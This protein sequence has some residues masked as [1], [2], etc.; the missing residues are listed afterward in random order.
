MPTVH[1]P[2]AATTSLNPHRSRYQKIFATNAGPNPSQRQQRNCPDYC[3]CDRDC[4]D[5]RTP[6]LQPC[7]SPCVTPSVYWPRS[8]SGGIPR[9][10][11]MTNWRNSESIQVAQSNLKPTVRL[12][13]G[14]PEHRPAQANQ[15]HLERAALGLRCAVLRTSFPCAS[16]APASCWAGLLPLVNKRRGFLRF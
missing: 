5:A 11:R 4:H 12:S 13:F 2:V 1:M 9:P 10:G 14:M 6:H 7:A 8:L 3:R 16:P 15:S